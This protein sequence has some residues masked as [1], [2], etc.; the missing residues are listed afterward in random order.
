M[1]AFG[2]VRIPR[3]NEGAILI[4]F[5]TSARPGPAELEGG[6]CRPEE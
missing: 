1:A 2:L 6:M 4:L 5:I 3:R